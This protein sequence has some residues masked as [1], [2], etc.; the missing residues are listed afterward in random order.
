V[1]R[2]SSRTHFEEFSI[3]II[4]LTN[5]IHFVS[6]TKLSISSIVFGFGEPEVAMSRS[7]SSSRSTFSTAAIFT[8]AATL[9]KMSL[10][11]YGYE[12]SIQV[13]ESLAAMVSDQD[14]FRTLLD[15][16]LGLTQLVE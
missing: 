9:Q 12:S 10:V 15:A 4:C 6:G 11:S 1:N 5:N 8:R 3:N 13:I 14:S 2:E 7:S 16:M